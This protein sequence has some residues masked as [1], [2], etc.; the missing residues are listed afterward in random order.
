MS[1]YVNCFTVIALSR[2]RCDFAVTGDHSEKET[3]FH[4]KRG[5][6]QIPNSGQFALRVRAGARLSIATAVLVLVLWMSSFAGVDPG[7]FKQAYSDVSESMLSNDGEVAEISNFNYQK[8]VAHFSFAEGRILLRRPVLG[9]PSV[10]MFVGKGSVSIDV[11]SHV[12]RQRLLAMTGDSTVREQFEICH[13]RFADSLDLQL[14]EKF[15]FVPGVLSAKDFQRVKSFQG[16][17]FFK[18]IPWHQTD[19]YFQLLRSAF[20]GTTGG[21]FWAS[22]G[23]Y[24]FSFDPDRPEEVEILFN[25]EPSSIVAYRAARFARQERCRQAELEWPAVLYPTHGAVQRTDLDLGGIDGMVILKGQSTL[26]VCQDRDSAQFLSLY[27]DKILEL[28]SALCG[29]RNITFQR[30][31]NFDHVGIVLPEWLHEHDTAAI[32]LWYHGRDYATAFPW[33]DNPRG[34]PH[35][36]QL[37]TSAGFSYILPDEA[38]NLGGDSARQMIGIPPGVSN[39]VPYFYQLGGGTDTTTL[40]TGWQ[41]PVQIVTLE[42]NPWSVWERQGRGDTL[43]K[44]L[45]IMYERFGPPTGVSR[46]FVLPCRSPLSHAGVLCPDYIPHKDLGGFS[47]AIGS[48][49]AAQWLS[50]CAESHS[51]REAWLYEAV[52]AYLRLMLVEAIAGPEHLLVGM[53]GDRETVLGVLERGDDVPLAGGASGWSPKGVW[54]IH[55]IRNLMNS[56]DTTRDT[57]FVAWLGAVVKEL[58]Q[59]AFSNKDFQELTEHYFGYELG[60]F[61]RK[62]LQETGIPTY[63]AEYSTSQREDGYYVDLEIVTEGVSSDFMMPVLVKIDKPS[64][65]AFANCFVLPNIKSYHLGPYDTKPTEMHFNKNCSVLSEDEIVRKR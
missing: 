3:D 36:L 56:V 23:R 24:V 55:M 60:W 42:N 64:G 50:S 18:P 11:P 5:Y 30:R 20:G 14:R 1:D 51:Y 2:S 63:R 62:W 41:M 46:I 6:F 52:S 59:G 54:V 32:T 34:Y 8:D 40:L 44:A 43:L 15:N 10:A 7:V 38:V 61:F 9:R 31:N 57:I 47:Y 21:F 26:K 65:A 25:R 37:S 17:F 49:V 27:L 12:E 13:I 53:R 19:N 48:G 29:G 45:E 58:N 33:V 28:D 22:F 4:T 16:D 39:E 35:A